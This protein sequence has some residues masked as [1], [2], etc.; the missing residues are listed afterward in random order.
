MHGITILS[1]KNCDFIYSLL[2]CLYYSLR[3]VSCKC[4]THRK[5][6]RLT[7]QISNRQDFLQLLK[8]QHFILIRTITKFTVFY[9]TKGLKVRL[10]AFSSKAC[11]MSYSM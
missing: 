5:N 1:E 8:Y 4:K 6:D 11:A 2:L 10:G 7:K 3:I 9:Q